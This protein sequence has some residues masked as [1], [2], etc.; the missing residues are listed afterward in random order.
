MED[1]TFSKIKSPASLSITL[2]DSNTLN[3]IKIMKA[4]GIFKMLSLWTYL[5]GNNTQQFH[6][7]E[8][9]IHK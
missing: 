5:S 2:G 8:P 6:E 7:I 3:P 9:K 1:L 4:I